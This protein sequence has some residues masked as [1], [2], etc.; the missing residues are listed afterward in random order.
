MIK[1]FFLALLIIGC[2]QEYDLESCNILS[3][4]KYKGIPSSFKKFDQN[5]KS[6]DIKYTQNLCQKALE[7]LIKQK[8]LKVIQNK[9]GPPVEHCFTGDDLK[10][11]N[12]KD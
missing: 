11:F 7:D 9:Y 3:M 4:E 2:Q 12:I 1:K 5:C 10:R 8:S 6:F